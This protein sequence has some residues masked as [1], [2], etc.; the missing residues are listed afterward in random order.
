MNRRFITDKS[1]I[2]LLM[3]G[4]FAVFALSF[5]YPTFGKLAIIIW[6][7]LLIFAYV[8]SNKLR[9]KG[10]MSDEQIYKLLDTTTKN[11]VF[12]MPFPLTVIDENNEVIWYNTP[13]IDLTGNKQMVGISLKKLM[14]DFP[15][16]FIDDSTLFSNFFYKGKWYRV[17]KHHIDTEKSPDLPKKALILYW[18]EDTEYRELKLRMENEYVSCITLIVD[19]YDE[20]RSSTPDSSRPLVMAEIDSVINAYFSQFN[21]MVRKYESDRYLVLVEMQY[22]AEIISRRFDILDEMRELNLGNKIP[23]TL[24]IGVAQNF[25]SPIESSKESVAA[26]EVA[27]GRGGDQAVVKKEGTY[28][29]FGGKSKAVEKRNKVKARVIADALR[30]LIDQ[31]DHVFIMGHKN[32]DM[33]AIGSGIGIWRAVANRNKAGYIVLNSSNPSIENLLKRMAIEEPGLGKYFIN[34]ETAIDLLGE[35]DLLIMMDHHQASFSEEPK[36]VDIIGQV[37]ILDHH[38]RGEDIVKNPILMYLEPYASSTSEL[39]TEILSY[40]EDDHQLTKFEA[41]ALMAGIMVDTKDFTYQTGVRT[42]EAAAMLKRAGADMAA[43]KQLFC[44]DLE[45]FRLR[46]SAIQSA[47]IYR[48]HMAIAWIRDVRHDSILIAAQAA[49]DLLHFNG[50]LASFVIAK[51]QNGVHISGRSTGEISVQLILEKLGGG[52]HLTS[53]GVQLKDIDVEQAKE[54][55]IRA[56]DEYKKEEN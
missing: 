20:V 37:V 14:P 38:R 4:S 45:T 50:I 25:L 28:Q 22:L 29:Y 39:V 52:G 36:L 17:F 44:D 30:G 46:S 41:D 27:L 6:I 47:E 9:S 35:N 48:D 15:K 56:I 34:G 8:D 3:F 5:A 23:I 24:S 21:A 1:K 16:S 42:F 11:A 26:V 19:N 31:A 7:G 53:A 55:L 51:L 43:V 49:D 2:L 54:R 13:F 40:M 33:D 10:I 12:Q 32:P 18:V